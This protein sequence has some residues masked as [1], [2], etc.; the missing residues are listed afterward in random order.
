MTEQAPL[1]G[2]SHRLV[3]AQERERP[4]LARELHDDI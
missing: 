2:L 1:P 3:E 4:R